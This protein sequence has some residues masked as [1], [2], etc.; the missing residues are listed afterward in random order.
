M[1]FSIILSSYLFICVRMMCF[2]K[3]LRNSAPLKFFRLKQLPDW[4]SPP[5]TEYQYDTCSFADIRQTAREKKII[6]IYT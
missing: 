4:G 5:P 3:T 1:K 6:C 2:D